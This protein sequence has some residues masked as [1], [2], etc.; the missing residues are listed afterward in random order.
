VT[1][2]LSNIGIKSDGHLPQQAM[3]V[4]LN[5]QWSPAVFFS[6]KIKGRQHV[7]LPLK[8]KIKVRGPEMV[9]PH[10]WTFLIKA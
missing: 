8:K 4:C 10:A 1:L 6:Q 3:V 7:V 9:D 2:R 5:K